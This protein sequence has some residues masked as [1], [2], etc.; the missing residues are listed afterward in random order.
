MVAYLFQAVNYLTHK[1]IVMNTLFEFKY[2]LYLHLIVYYKTVTYSLIIIIMVLKDINSTTLE[3][4]NQTGFY[5]CKKHFFKFLTLQGHHFQTDFPESTMS[6][7]HRGPSKIHRFPSLMKILF[8]PARRYSLAEHLFGRTPP[9][10][11]LGLS[12]FHEK[13]SLSSFTLYILDTAL[14]GEELPG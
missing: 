10:G 6:S 1:F 5:L 14:H 3:S 7:Q 11:A 13:C 8:L 12:C 9:S 4:I 2:N